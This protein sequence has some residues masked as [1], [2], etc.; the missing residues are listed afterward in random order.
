[1]PKA[2]LDASALLAL[3]LKEPGHERVLT[4][5]FADSL[6]ATVNLAEVC[7]R[8]ALRSASE[9]VIR[10]LRRRAPLVV[11]PVDEDLA[12]ESAVMILHTRSEGLS[13][14]DRICLALAQEGGV[15]GAN[16]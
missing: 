10:N 3:L 15:A 9:E 16:G 1:M 7:A 8:Y 4:A 13:L 5:L 14:G 6:I 12:V 11:V 2:V